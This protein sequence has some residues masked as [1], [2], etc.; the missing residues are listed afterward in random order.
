MLDERLLP[1]LVVGVCRSCGAVRHPVPNQCPAC[2][3]PV[4][5]RAAETGRLVSWTVV[6][7]APPGFVAPYTVAWVELEVGIGVMGRVATPGP[8]TL[9]F[10]AVVSVREGRSP[11]RPPQVW[12]VVDDG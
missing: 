11:D 2:A 10:G 9:R 5:R 8:V 1:P 12:L 6:H 3:G 4:E 7:H